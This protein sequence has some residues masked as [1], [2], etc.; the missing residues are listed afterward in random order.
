[1]S[2]LTVGTILASLAFLAASSGPAPAKD[3][4]PTLKFAFGPGKVEP[5]Y[6]QVTPDTV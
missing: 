3:K 5:G 6:T 1:M 2:R 4:G